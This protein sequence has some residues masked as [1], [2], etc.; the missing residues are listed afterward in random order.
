DILKDQVELHARFSVIVM[1][2]LLG[3]LAVPLSQTRPR[4]G[5]YGRLVFALV[6]YLIYS[7]ALTVGRVEA[8][9]A[10]V[11]VGVGIWSI[12]AVVAAYIFW[13]LGQRE[14][15][16]RRPGSVSHATEPSA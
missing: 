4:E 5:R 10:E 6:V 12:H 9:N 1:V 16:W 2:L 8:D 7:N 11:T 13:L 15:W 3:L 14:G